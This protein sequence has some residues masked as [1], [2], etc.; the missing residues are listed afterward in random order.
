[1]ESLQQ[2]LDEVIAAAAAAMDAKLTLRKAKRD[3]LRFVLEQAPDMLD[4]ICKVD[5]EQLRRM[6]R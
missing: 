3:C 1:M 6:R 5:V 2:H 4:I